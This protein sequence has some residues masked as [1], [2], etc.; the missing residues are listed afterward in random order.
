M[1]KNLENLGRPINHPLTVFR[2]LQRNIADLTEIKITSLLSIEADK[3]DIS[4]IISSYGDSCL[5]CIRV[6]VKVWEE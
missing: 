2:V 3:A 1:S 6:S 5:S 4:G